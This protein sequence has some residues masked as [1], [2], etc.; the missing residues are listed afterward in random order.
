M[1]KLLIALVAVASVA[2]APKNEPI[3]LVPYPNHVEVGSGRYSIVDAEVW[4]QESVDERTLAAVTL[5]TEQLNTTAGG[6]REVNVVAE[7][8]NEG[9]R[10]VVDTTVEQEGYRLDVTRKGVEI[11]ASQ[12]AG[13]QYAIQTVKQLLPA[14]VYGK[15]LAAD[16]DWLYF[17]SKV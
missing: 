1:K 9:I 2:C 14:E 8:P 5:F 17:S 12:F 6:Q 16:E 7:L 11:R 15:E 3:A 13:F 10:F 4:C